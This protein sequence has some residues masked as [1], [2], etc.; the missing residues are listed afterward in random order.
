MVIFY[1][2]KYILIISKYLAKCPRLNPENLHR[3]LKCQKYFLGGGKFGDKFVL[4]NYTVPVDISVVG[5]YTAQQFITTKIHNYTN[6]QI[7]K[8]AN[9]QIHSM[10]IFV[11]Q[12][13]GGRVCGTVYWSN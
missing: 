5:K 11:E 8:Y 4:Q 13:G 12:T 1:F 7:H 10:K 6:T 2:K 9:T 3:A